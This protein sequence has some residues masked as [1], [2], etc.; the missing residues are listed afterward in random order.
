MLF[1]MNINAQIVFEQGYFI[2]EQNQ[3]VKA[4]LIPLLLKQVCFGY[5]MYSFL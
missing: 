4:L 3:Y 5:L 2:N 1:C